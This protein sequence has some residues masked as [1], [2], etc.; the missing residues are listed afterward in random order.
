ME[1]Q[2]K[3]LVAALTHQ[4]TNHLVLTHVK[5]LHFENKHLTILVD[6]AGPLHELSSPELDEHLRKGL[7][8]VYGTDITYELKLMHPGHHTTERQ[9]KIPHSTR[10]YPKRG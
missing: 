2:I 8:K 9:K 7:E 6:N 10:E 4:H 5:E 3:I 1:H